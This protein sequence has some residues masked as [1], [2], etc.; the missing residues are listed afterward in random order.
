MTGE[1]GGEWRWLRIRRA[2]ASDGDTEDEE[3]AYAELVEYLRVATQLTYEE[4][5]DFRS[6]EE[7]SLPDESATLH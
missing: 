3:S 4:L 2:M 5:A 6:P 7:E 1:G